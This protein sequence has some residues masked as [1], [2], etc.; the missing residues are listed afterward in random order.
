MTA[1]H[2]FPSI[3]SHLGNTES[4]LAP[5]GYYRS[6]LFIAPLSPNTLVA[7]AGPVLSLLERL[8]LSSTLPPIDQIR[9]NIEH[10]LR[11]FYSKV[12]ASQYTPDLINIAYYLLAATVDELLGKNYVRVYNNVA[13]F[14]SFTP[15]TTDNSQPQKRF[16]DILNFV[17][18]RP[19]QYLDLIEL[20]YF[21][22]IAGFEGEHH[23]KADGRQ[24]LDN[25]IEN[26]YQLIQQYRFNKAHRLFNDSPIPKTIKKNYH[27]T[28][29][30]IIIA[31]G[32]VSA[33]FFTSQ[34]LL[35]NK[36]KQ[37]LFGHTQLALLDN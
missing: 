26:L 5:K 34:I 31:I 24:T 19:N 2:H 21:C 32:L 7:A 1:E 4:S 25:H 9:D 17:K 10:E 20:I 16:F 36:A 33:V 37:V 3:V 13:E 35:E 11:A 14:K 22:L 6:K 12:H 29:L 23:L 28:L 27:A 18:E 30:T 15:L 8:C